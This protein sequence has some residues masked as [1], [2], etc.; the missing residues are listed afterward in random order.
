[1]ANKKNRSTNHAKLAKKNSDKPAKRL[2][3]VIEQEFDRQGLSPEQRDERYDALERSLDARDPAA[4]IAGIIEDHFD[5]QGLSEEE[6]NIRVAAAGEK[7]KAAVERSARPRR[8]RGAK[9]ALP[10]VE[11]PA[12]LL[13]DPQR[14]N[15]VLLL[16]LLSACNGEAT[17]TQEQL[18]VDESQYN[19]VFARTIDNKKIV[20]SIVSSQSGILSAP[21]GNAGNMGEWTPPQNQEPLHFPLPSVAD[22]Q[23]QDREAML[24]AGTGEMTAQE[25]YLRA[26]EAEKQPATTERGAM[27]QMPFEVGERPGD[28]R[29]MPDLGA[30]AR[31]ARTSE[32][33]ESEQARIDQRVQNEGR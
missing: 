27:P 26:A 2:H 22:V 7:V 32:Q 12:E 18:E 3:S 17:F 6:R 23:P 31:Q 1:M 14:M 5:E 13:S 11:I 20:V 28:T 15:F 30:Y 29:P 16:A 21:R 10:D 8:D 4:Q 33:I 19:I 25:K 24:R 9:P